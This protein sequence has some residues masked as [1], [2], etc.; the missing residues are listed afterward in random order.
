VSYS[1][2]KKTKTFC[3]LPWVHLEIQQEGNTYPCC[4]SQFN[5]PLGNTHNNS[6]EEIWNSSKL[7]QLRLDMLN[8]KRSNYC[9]DCYKIEECG[10]TSL[11]IRHNL[12]HQH[13]FDLV[14]KTHQDGSLDDFT[15][16][17]LGLRFSN[18]CNIKCQY[19]D[20]NYSTSWFADQRTLGINPEHLN[21]TESFNSKSDLLD[22]INRVLP[23][24]DSI[25]MAGGEPLLD[26]THLVLLD[27][28]IERGRTDIQ[29]IYNSNLTTLTPFNQNVVDR[30]KKFDKVIIDVSIDSHEERNDYIRT[31]SNW[32]KIESNFLE[33][34][35]YK[36]IIT[37]VFCTV[38]IFNVL[39]IVESIKYW[40]DKGVTEEN[41]I[42]FNLLEA[43]LI[44]NIQSLDSKKK[45][46]LT[47]TI[48]DY[49]KYIFQNS[50]LVGAMYL[51]NQLKNL[52]NFMNL[53]DTSHEREGF[54]SKCDKL[55][56]IRGLNW[57]KT[58]PE[59]DY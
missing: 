6:P 59:L 44:H 16:K 10:G 43:P 22:F 39:T 45:T 41:K 49:S 40:L 54:I 53:K 18:I 46:Q 17:F 28:L 25:Y 58:F 27:L 30:W 52:I 7:K 15:L 5:K 51:T 26:K 56:K 55:D 13:D 4:R 47:K 31:G 12:I 37:R 3:I 42:I 48:Q 9:T 8:D 23:T 32:K 21:L 33:L 19:C 24:L 20:Q 11:R 34:K 14:E 36:N 1:K 35:Q 29:L 38:T 50:D 57:R 2:Y